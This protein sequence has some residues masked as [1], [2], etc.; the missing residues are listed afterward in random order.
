M[1]IPVWP[2]WQRCKAD[3]NIIRSDLCHELWFTVKVKMTMT[4]H[5]EFTNKNIPV[6]QSISSRFLSAYPACAAV[7]CV[8][9]G[10]IQ[11]VCSQNWFCHVVIGSWDWQDNASECTRRCH[12]NKESIVAPL[13]LHPRAFG[14]RCRVPHWI[15]S[16]IKYHPGWTY[17][18]FASFKLP[19]FNEYEMVF[20]IA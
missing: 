12:F 13:A 9:V 20:I 10:L 5:R 8:H 16:Q 18:F 11:A 6:S 7:C 4:Y 15:W 14:A 1:S 2:G 3:K 17:F 19:L